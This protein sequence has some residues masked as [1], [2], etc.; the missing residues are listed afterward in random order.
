M[1]T[2]FAP[3]APNTASVTSMRLPAASGCSISFILQLG[4]SAPAGEKAD[5]RSLGREVGLDP[6]GEGATRLRTDRVSVTAAFR[7][8]RLVDQN[9]AHDRVSSW[10]VVIIGVKTGSVKSPNRRNR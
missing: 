8:R 1:S 4:K 2:C 3:S 10:L 5:G 7:C 6:L 9:L